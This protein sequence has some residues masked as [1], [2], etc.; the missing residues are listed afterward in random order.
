MIQFSKPRRPFDKTAHID[1][2]ATN[3]RE[4]MPTYDRRPAPSRF[5]PG[6]FVAANGGTGNLAP[7]AQSIR[8]QA[9]YASGLP[10]SLLASTVGRRTPYASSYAPSIISQAGRDDDASSIAGSSIA[11]S[12]ADRLS[13]AGDS[14][15]KQG[16]GDDDT[17]SQVRCVVARL[18]DRAH[19]GLRAVLGRCAGGR[20]DL[21][22][23][24]RFTSS[25]PVLLRTHTTAN[26]RPRRGEGTTRA[27]DC[28][29]PA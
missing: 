7:D 26:G 4:M 24:D 16:F 18:P 6:G 17:R 14:E 8:S 13:V 19:Q 3:A 20:H 11:Y 2:F 25:R 23:S 10:A 22:T 15:Y 9:S 29:R 5:E 28:S 21:V 1:R 12:Q 27:A